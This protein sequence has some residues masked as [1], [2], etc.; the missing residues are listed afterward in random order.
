MRPGSRTVPAADWKTLIS[1]LDPQAIAYANEGGADLRGYRT[2]R[3]LHG[4]LLHK[5]LLAQAVKIRDLL[6]APDHAD[7]PLGAA[8]RLVRALAPGAGPVDPG[9][10]ADGARTTYWAS[11]AAHMAV[12][13]NQAGDLARQLRRMADLLDAAATGCAL[14]SADDQH[15]QNAEDAY[16]WAGGTPEQATARRTHTRHGAHL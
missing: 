8:D 1:G 14:L 5:A 15:A 12:T 6:R 9:V 10:P 11:R 4:N 3:D 2:D 7:S 13:G 16:L